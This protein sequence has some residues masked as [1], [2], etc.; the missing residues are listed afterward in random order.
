MS[1]GMNFRNLKSRLTNDYLYFIDMKRR[2]RE[3][4]LK[5][6]R[7]EDPPSKI[8]E[9][10]I[11][12]YKKGGV[13]FEDDQKERLR[14]TPIKLTCITDNSSG[15]LLQWIYVG[16]TWWCRKIGKR[17]QFARVMAIYNDETASRIEGLW[18]ER[19][20]ATKQPL[21]VVYS[22]DRRGII[23]GHNEFEIII[24]WDDISI[25]N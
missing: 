4:F 5:K 15:Q 10:L 13:E 21:K 6:I 23:T 8:R 11:C 25:N 17:Y 12:V 20:H 18:D 3:I 16:T 22:G 1:L 14:N 7:K 2:P 9:K 24:H 19:R